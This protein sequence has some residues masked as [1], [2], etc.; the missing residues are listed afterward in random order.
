MSGPAPEHEGP[1]GTPD[2]GRPA[3]DVPAWKMTGVRCRVGG[4]P[5]YPSLR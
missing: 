5:K 1:P 2:D 4:A 3:G